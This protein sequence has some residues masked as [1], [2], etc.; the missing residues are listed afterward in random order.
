M[1]LVD[2]AE[3]M[4]THW[5]EATFL[6]ETLVKMAQGVDK[7]GM[8]LRFTFGTTELEGKDSADKFVNSMKKACPSKGVRTDLRMS[9]G[10]ILSS[11][12][13]K[14]KAKAKFPGNKVKDLVL[15]V[16]T[17]GIWAGMQDKM[18]IAKQLRT[19]AGQLDYDL[20]QRPFS[21]QF[22]QFGDDK[23]ASKA[24]RYLD[25]YRRDL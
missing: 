11:Y 7:D 15:V 20:K 21:I 23:D 17:D 14:L 19:I 16:L 10:D 2:N 6:L 9:L 12:A 24:L 13:D 3:S 18:A 22:I 1:F 5:Y 25:D 4:G 8:D